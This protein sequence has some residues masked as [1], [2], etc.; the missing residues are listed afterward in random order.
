MVLITSA[1]PKTW[2]TVSF[3]IK[4][5]KEHN[6]QPRDYQSNLFILKNL[7]VFQTLMPEKS[8]SKT[9]AGQNGKP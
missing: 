5:E 2:K 1:Q 8:K 4:K 9:G 7:N 6:T 3:D